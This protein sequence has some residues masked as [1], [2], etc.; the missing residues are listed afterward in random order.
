MGTNWPEH[1]KFTKEDL[2]KTSYRELSC[3]KGVGRAAIERRYE[4]LREMVS[5]E[6]S[7]PLQTRQTD[8]EDVAT[9]RRQLENT[10]RTVISQLRSNGTDPGDAWEILHNTQGFFLGEIED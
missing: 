7:Q 8:W 1:M 5:G 10:L 3:R 2:I 9:M 4:A 6:D